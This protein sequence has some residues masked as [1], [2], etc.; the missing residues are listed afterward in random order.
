[1]NLVGTK[2]KEKFNYEVELIGHH[3]TLKNKNPEDDKLFHFLQKDAISCKE[4]RERIE[5]HKEKLEEYD[6]ILKEF[7]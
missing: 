7:N 3:M 4:L 2:T 6:D 1:M 5:Y